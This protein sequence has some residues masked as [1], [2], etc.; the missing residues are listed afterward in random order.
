M[1]RALAGALVAAWL[2]GAAACVR[3]PKDALLICHNANCASPGTVDHDDELAAL[4]ASL[5]L[6]VDGRPPFD[7]VEIDS[8]WDAASAR[9]LFAHGAGVAAPDAAE[10]TRRI[11]ALLASDGPASWNGQRFYLKIE[12]KPDVAS[13]GRG[14]A[15]D[16]AIAHADCVLD[17]LATI[18]AVA[19]AHGR[20]VTALLD[21]AN[22]TL[23]LV[24][25][26]RPRWP[27]KRAGGSFS[28]ELEV[29][30]DTKVPD[31]L[32][33]DVLTVRW[34]A[35]VESMRD[36]L[37]LRGKRVLS[38]GRAPSHANLSELAY[39]QPTYIGSNDALLVRAWLEGGR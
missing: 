4:D 37:R 20:A 39:L 7:G 17:Q 36:D 6:R 22:P 28:I 33:P 16:E 26:Q 23:L 35:I 11:A 9:C 29:D 19:G 31:G 34:G 30:Y 3:A 15:P 25:T 38:W 24:V 10:A 1:R 8:V 14:H 32:E 18:E 13:D 12:L 27:G 2:G 21:S 5:A